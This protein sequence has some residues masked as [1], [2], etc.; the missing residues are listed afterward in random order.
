MAQEEPYEPLQFDSDSF[1]MRT[2]VK[3]DAADYRGLHTVFV[4][5]GGDTY[6]TLE[7]GETTVIQGISFIVRKGGQLRLKNVLLKRCHIFL[8][9]GAEVDIASSGIDHCEFEGRSSRGAV[10]PLLKITNCSIHGGAWL[11]AAN[12][13]GLEMVD[14]VVRGQTAKEHLLRV[15]VNT[16]ATPVTYASQ[17][18]VRS[19]RFENCLIHPTLMIM[20]SSLTVQKSQGLF[21][22]D[23]ELFHSS[24]TADKPAPEL[25]LP[26][27]WLENL[28]E[29][30]PLIG[31]GIGIRSVAE[32]FPGGCSLIATVEEKALKMSGMCDKAAPRKLLEELQRSPAGLSNMIVEAQVLQAEVAKSMEALKLKQSQVNG[33]LIMS[34]SGGK[35]TGSVTRMNMTAVPGKTSLRFGQKV[36]DDMAT[37]LGAVEKFMRIRHQTLPAGLDLEVTFEN[38]YSPKDG[39]SAAVA[40]ALLTESIMTGRTWD[41]AF[42]VTGDMNADGSVQPIGGVAAKVRGATL[43]ACKIIGVPLKNERAVSDIIVM[44]GPAALASIHVFA[45]AQF[46]QALELA[47]LDR[48]GTLAEATAEFE[49]IRSV[50][51]RDVRQM[52]LILRTPQAVT[53]LQSVLQKAP[54]SLSAKYLL[55]YAQG[56]LP[57]NLSLGGSLEAADSS[58]IGLVQSIETDFK[59]SLSTLRPDELGGTLNRLRNLRPR[60]DRRVWPYVDAVVDYGE[61]VRTEVVNPSRTVGKFNEMVG[62]ARQ[63][64]SIAGAAKKT[65][66]ADPQV[67][68]DLGL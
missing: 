10:K 4:G 21:T 26:V 43:G 55:M 57:A 59:G 36:G 68:E 52:P 7:F 67:R 14:C 27:R 47:S 2:S 60:L 58:A 20:S 49:V 25:V 28:P 50:L 3:L 65:L 11:C 42:A 31:C 22:A 34:L 8:E 51:Q 18:L 56:R 23:A 40:C 41:P 13:L 54:H 1:E 15:E 5:A 62:R 44:E 19:T 9:P 48:Q 24:G 38:K 6:C 12:H 53:R 64:A 29:T 39:P 33:L 46:D 16:Q 30:P 32:P 66:L 63:A 45:L 37:S 17:P 61:I 35:E